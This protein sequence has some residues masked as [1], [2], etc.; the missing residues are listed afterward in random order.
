[1]RRAVPFALG[2]LALA[3]S[4]SSLLV[5]LL[6]GSFSAHMAMHMGVVAVAAP[7]LALGLA[8]GRY[9][10]V[11]GTPRLFP[12][13]A[14]S[15]AE[16]IAVWAWHAPAL[17]HFARHEVLGLVLEQCTFFATGF[18]VWMSALG[19]PPELRSERAGQGCLALLLTSMHMTLLGA[20]LAL[21]PRP[22]YGFHAHGA[23]GSALSAIDDQHLGGAIMLTVG[24]LVYLVGG[25]ALVVEM[26][27]RTAARQ[28]ASRLRRE[29]EGRCAVTEG[30]S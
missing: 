22:L 18:W 21:P 17:H 11:R 2:L 8:G 9:D 1:M 19:G 6:P 20:L 14:A 13:L 3:A 24:G 29:G 15:V 25:L 16:L 4:W 30:P 12:P 28:P 7:L 5:R 26:V 23:H 10:P 27:K